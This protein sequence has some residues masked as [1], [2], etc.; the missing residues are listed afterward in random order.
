LQAVLAD[1]SIV[2]PRDTEIWNLLGRHYVSQE[3]ADDCGVAVLA[4]LTGR[5]LGETMDWIDWKG[6]PVEPWEM[7]RALWRDGCYLRT[8]REPSDVGQE[9]WPPEPF[10]EAHYAM[11]TA[12]KG[13]HWTIMDASGRVFDPWDRSRLSLDVYGAVHQVTGLKR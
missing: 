5:T 1:P 12:T 8:A 13:G 11:V 3:G 7:A 2:I 10:A 4:M 9:S 6:I